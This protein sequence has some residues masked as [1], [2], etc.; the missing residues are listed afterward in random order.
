MAGETAD[1]RAIFI[2][3]DDFGVA[4]TYHDGTINGILVNDF[5]EV[6]AGGGVG[7]A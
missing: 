3:F 7:L 6:D 5:V 2:G 4:A 1:D